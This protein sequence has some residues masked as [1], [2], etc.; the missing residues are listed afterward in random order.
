MYRT[1]EAWD[2]AEAA[3]QTGHTYR[4]FDWQK[5]ARLIEKHKPELAEAGLAEDWEQTATVI[6][7]GG[8]AR[9]RRQG[10]PGLGMGHANTRDG[11]AGE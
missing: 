4:V 9:N 6:W 3:T 2:A 7:S 11:W 5:A 8:Q 10:Q 1:L